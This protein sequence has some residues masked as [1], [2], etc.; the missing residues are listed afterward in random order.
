MQ[1]LMGSFAP[2]EGLPSS[3]F[4]MFVLQA[5]R[6]EQAICVYS[7]AAIVITLAIA[8]CCSTIPYNTELHVADL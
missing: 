4:A 5:M 3:T 2:H 8:A 1:Q 6:K 7:C